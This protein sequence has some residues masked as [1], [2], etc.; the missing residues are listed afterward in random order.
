MSI[1]LGGGVVQC[2]SVRRYGSHQKITTQLISS[3]RS[4][5]FCPPQYTRIARNHSSSLGAFLFKFHLL[6]TGPF[7]ASNRLSISCSSSHLDFTN[8]T[9]WVISFSTL[10]FSERD[11]H[12]HPPIHVAECV[13]KLFY[14]KPPF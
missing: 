13:L 6:A 12:L 10:H 3:R 9:R 4:S 2:N 8:A 7:L 14:N 1:D 11:G 5:L